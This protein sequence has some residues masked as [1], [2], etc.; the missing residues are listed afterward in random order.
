MCLVIWVKTD[1]ADRDTLAAAAR[2]ASAAG[3]RVEM[4]SRSWWPWARRAPALATITEDG[5]CACGLLSDDADW[6]ADT[7][8]M[9]PEILEPLARTLQILADEGPA[10]L[11]LEALW[12]GDAPLETARVTV[13]ELVMLARSSR[14]GTRTR[15]E[16]SSSN[17][18]QA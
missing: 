5:G 13:T 4:E 8:L 7:W 2:K 6:N 17:R 11:F 18:R 9:R 14:L 15:Y 10:T 1:A 12:A 3:L 16:V